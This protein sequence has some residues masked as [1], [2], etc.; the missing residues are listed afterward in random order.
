[1]RCQWKT[2]GSAPATPHGN[3]SI[4]IVIQSQQYRTWYC[5]HESQHQRCH[6]CSHINSS[7]EN[8]S[9]VTGQAP[10]TLEWKNCTRYEVRVYDS[11]KTGISKRHCCRFVRYRLPYVC[12]FGGHT[13]LQGLACSSESRPRIIVASTTTS[14]RWL[15]IFQFSYLEYFVTFFCLFQLHYFRLSF[16]SIF[17]ML[18]VPFFFRVVRLS[19]IFS[20]LF[21]LC[22]D[23]ARFFYLK[24]DVFCEPFFHTYEYIRGSNLAH[25]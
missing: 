13:W 7:S 1:M 16:F 4:T 17:L 22:F 3:E 10:I 24:S 19:S 15:V 11:C 20:T 14:S 6:C 2:S 23:F 12:L 9:V 25:L 21:R 8:Q 18:L 5:L